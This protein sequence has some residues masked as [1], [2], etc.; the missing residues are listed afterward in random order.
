MKG[1]RIQRMFR[2]IV[3]LVFMV[4]RL[5]RKI[6][7]GATAREDPAQNPRNGPFRP[8]PAERY[9]H[10]CLQV[11]Q[12]FKKEVKEDHGGR[13]GQGLFDEQIGSQE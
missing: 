2:Q 6:P 7:G 13:E 4:C 10:D 5:W 1:T 8:T 12:D 11:E 9:Q 3:T